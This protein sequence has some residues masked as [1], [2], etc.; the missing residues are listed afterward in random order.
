MTKPQP[1]ETV[2]D[3]PFWDGARAG[4][5]MLQYND[6][7]G[8]PQMYPRPAGIGSLGNALSWREA[9]G[10]GTIYSWTAVRSPVNKSFADEVPIYLADIELDEGVRMLV[11][12][13]GDPPG[14]D[15]IGADVEIVFEPNVEGGVPLPCARLR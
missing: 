1:T 5:L 4:K 8:R 3:A 2:W 12:V 15:S 10:R 14:D 13:L 11:R 7:N 6:D 9:S